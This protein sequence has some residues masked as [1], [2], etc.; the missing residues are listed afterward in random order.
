[1]ADKILDAFVR[2]ALGAGQSREAIRKAL[3]DAGWARD[4]IDDALSAYADADFPVPVPR[5]RR[6][7]SAREAFL[8]IVYFALLGVVAGYVGGLAFAFIDAMFADDLAAR[9]W[10]NSVSSLRWGI[11]ALVVGYPI[12]IYLGARLGAARRA[13]PE[14]QTSRV[15]AW[16]TYVTLMFAALVLI[17]D[18]ISVVYHFLSGELGARFLSKAAVVAV[19]S[20][21]ILWNYGRDAERSDAS[22]DWPGRA[23]AIAATLVTAAL[24]IWA[25]T[26]VRTPQSARDALADEERVRDLGVIV[27][28]VDCHRSYS[29]AL[30]ES[31]DALDE[32][33]SAR[34]ASAPVAAGCG[35]EVPADPS[36]RLPYAYTP[37]GG[38]EY[39]LCVTFQHGW[40]DE[41][42][43]N[44]PTENPR[45]RRLH[46]SF[47]GSAGYRYIDLPEGPGE[48]CFEF[49]AVD[50]D[51]DDA[52]G[53][54]VD[55]NE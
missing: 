5:P 12:F 15:R 17:G 7:G 30:P 50:F 13:N 38:D 29:G 39:R 34:A 54:A 10:R 16:L 27:R 53:V 52:D 45:R 31:L 14:R 4:Q 36:T 49:T 1:M 46:R 19:I 51:A 55:E 35:A 20:G 26:V 23:L 8:Y 6:Y 32:A 37:L 44:T 22:V 48:R 11:A 18:L 42:Y 25:F 40:P 3:G 21:A 2:D 41:N 33:L 9:N 24:V 43:Y 28:L 47:G